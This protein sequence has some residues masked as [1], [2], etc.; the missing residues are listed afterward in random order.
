MRP[1][2]TP[3]AA[4]SVFCL[5]SLIPLGKMSWSERPRGPDADTAAPWGAQ[6]VRLAGVGV[7]L[8]S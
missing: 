6:A 4:C 3:F 7:H 5:H 1:K 8:V 2:V